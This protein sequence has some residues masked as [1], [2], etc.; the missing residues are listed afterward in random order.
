MTTITEATISLNVTEAVSVPRWLGAHMR[1]WLIA[2]MPEALAELAHPL[3][4]RFPYTVSDLLPV[5]D[6]RQ[7][8][9]TLEPTQTYR[10]RITTLSDPLSD[11]LAD[12]ADHVPGHAVPISDGASL[13]VSVATVQQTTDDTLTSRY[14]LDVGPTA[15]R[16]ELRLLS[17]AVFRHHGMMSSLPTPH[18]VFRGLIDTWNR[19]NTNIQLH[20]DAAQ[21]AE[22][23][24]T[25][26]VLRLHSQTIRLPGT[27]YPPLTGST[28]FVRFVIRSRD[29]YWRG[30]THALAAYATYASIGAHTAVGMGQVRMENSQS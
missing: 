15:D 23:C 7:P 3:D 30:L 6:V 27:Q 16:I 28:G 22:E 11:W 4:G 12:W 5:P 19:F 8:Q 13:L 9:R 14:A 21:F 10:L 18:L 24:I 17:P 25:T 2:Q 20:P 29:R 26:S 1:D